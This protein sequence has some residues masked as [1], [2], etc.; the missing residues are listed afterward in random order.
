MSSKVLA[1][2]LPVIFTSE[3]PAAP[4]CYRSART[5]APTAAGLPQA[6]PPA[7]PQQNAPQ[8]PP[9]PEPRQP[10]PSR[11]TVDTISS[12]QSQNTE[13]H[14][15]SRTR[16]NDHPVTPFP[17]TCVQCRL[18]TTVR[19]FVDDAS[20]YRGRDWQ[21]DHEVRTEAD[22]SCRRSL[23]SGSLNAFVAWRTSVAAARV[24][25]SIRAV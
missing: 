22:G 1:I 15:S 6:P 23:L 3:T 11:T 16:G 17:K 10:P 21:P 13:A 18:L 24:E 19:F 25:K 12:T 2:S 20:L 4:H 5:P 8:H 9:P 7:S 14:A